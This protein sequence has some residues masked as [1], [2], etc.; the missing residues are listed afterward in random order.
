MIHGV[1]RSARIALGVVLLIGCGSAQ[2]PI[3]YEYDSLPGGAYGTNLEAGGDVDGDGCRDY[4]LGE[5]SQ[6]YPVI[7]PG[8]LRVFSGRTGSEIRTFYVPEGVDLSWYSTFAIDFCNA[9]DVDGDGLADIA[10]LAGAPVRY[11]MVLSGLTGDPLL[12][13]PLLGTQGFASS[14]RNLGDLDHDGVDE[15]GCLVFVTATLGRRVFVFSGSSLESLF[16]TPYVPGFDAKSFQNA[17][18]LTGDGLDDIVIGDPDFPDSAPDSQK[19]G[20]VLVFSGEGGEFLFG[21][22]GP[23]PLV[24]VSGAVPSEYGEGLAALGDLNGDGHDDFAVGAPGYQPGGFWVYSGFDASLIGAVSMSGLGEH[25]GEVL[26]GP[27]DVDG[28]GVPDI[29]VGQ[30]RW[31]LPMYPPTGYHHGRIAVF[32]GATLNLL[33]QIHGAAYSSFGRSATALGDLN[34]DGFPEIAALRSISTSN[35][36]SDRLRVYSFSGVRRYGIG[37]GGLQTLDADWQ[38]GPPGN[39]AQGTL[40]VA[41]GVPGGAGFF[42]V[43]LN[44]TM[45][46]LMGLPVLVDPD[47]QQ[48]LATAPFVFDAQGNYSVPASIHHPTAAGQLLRIQFFSLVSP[49][50]S[51]NGLEFLL[52]P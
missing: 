5:P 29:L 12:M 19:T 30:P 51:S 10:C 34:G 22:T 20:A 50:A 37:L 47:P 15:L 35:A 13:K 45:D 6:V 8:V 52:V 23:P 27:G 33:Y 48:I 2:L 21:L 28:D 14:I 42:A 32:S 7:G 11:L 36:L 49:Y 25:F 31:S 18:D 24:T 40:V 26:A 43:T 46:E 1:R 9:G 4:L 41:G 17:G 38:P 39:P 16:T 3:R 44:A